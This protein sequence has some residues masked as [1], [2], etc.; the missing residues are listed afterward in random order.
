V[1][2]QIWTAI[3]LGGLA[4]IALGAA[5]STYIE[6]S[7]HLRYLGRR[8]GVSRWEGESLRDFE[9]R[10]RNRIIIRGG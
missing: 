5:W 6:H 1:T 3:A 8:Y 2:W 10:I 9:T 7:E 4:L